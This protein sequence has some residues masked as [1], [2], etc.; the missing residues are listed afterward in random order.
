MTKHIDTGEYI[1]AQQERIDRLQA[2]LQW[3]R[4]NLN[5]GYAKLPANV[6]TINKNGPLVKI[7][8]PFLCPVITS[9]KLVNLTACANQ[10]K[11]VSAVIQHKI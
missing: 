7:S 4:T 8:G 6:S 3:H 5:N 10:H 9:T 11:E 2:E 1:Q